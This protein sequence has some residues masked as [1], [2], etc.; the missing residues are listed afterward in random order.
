MRDASVT[1]FSIGEIETMS[2]ARCYAG[3]TAGLVRPPIRAMIALQFT[4]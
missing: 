3:D 2:A 4:V 1:L